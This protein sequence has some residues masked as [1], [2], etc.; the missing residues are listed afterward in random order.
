MSPIL[1]TLASQFSGKPFGSFESI[2]T[3]NVGSGGTSTASFTSIPATYTHLQIRAIARG[4]RSDSEQYAGGLYIQLNSN[5]LTS[6]HQLIGKGASATAL[7]NT[8]GLSNGTLVMWV[9]ASNANAS[10]FGAVIVDILD[11]KNTNKNKVVR[12]LS[13]NDLN[14]SGAIAMT[15]G[16]WTSASAITSIT[17]GPTDGV[18]TIPQYSSFA[19]YGIKGA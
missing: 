9:P 1:G 2:A 13:G 14:G 16:L 6:Q 19:L 11:Y 4:G 10:I 15:S 5:F 3:V 18:G 8:G 12:I 7:A 17:F